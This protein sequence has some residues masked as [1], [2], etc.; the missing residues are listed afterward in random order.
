M[1][2]HTKINKHTLISW[3]KNQAAPPTALEKFCCVDWMYRTFLVHLVMGVCAFLN[4]Q[5]LYLQCVCFNI[6]V[7]IFLQDIFI[8]CSK[9]LCICFGFSYMF[10]KAA[11]H[12]S[13]WKC[14]GQL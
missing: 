13:S 14:F 4:L 11:V 10:F 8:I 3:V 1:L 12:F 9:I 5:F 7:L 2:Q 6:I